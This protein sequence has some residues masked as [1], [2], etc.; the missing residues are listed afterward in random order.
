MKTSLDLFRKLVQYFPSSGGISF[1]FFEA[2]R[3][4]RVSAC[5]FYSEA[6]LGSLW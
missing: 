4:I 5:C 3:S 1:D 2:A 6:F